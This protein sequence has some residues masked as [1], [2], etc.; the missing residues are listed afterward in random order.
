MRCAFSKRNAVAGMILAC[1]CYVL[2]VGHV[3]SALEAARPL[4]IKVDSIP[5]TELSDAAILFITISNGLQ[6][7]RALKVIVRIGGLGISDRAHPPFDL[8]VGQSR[9]EVFKIARPLRNYFVR[10]SYNVSG[11]NDEVVRTVEWPKTH[12]ESIL[13]LFAPVG[14]TLLGTMLGAWLLDHFS[15]RRERERA[16]VDWSRMLFEKYEKGYR[17]FLREWGGV[18]SSLIL[19]RQFEVLK[20]NCLVP[21][22]IAEAY[23]QTWAVVSSD[24]EVAA[25]KDEACAS[26]RSVIENFFREPW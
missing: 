24:K 7:H 14:G 18:S 25:R 23:N 21:A 11:K 5:P 19:S 13:P 9:L 3:A 17:D 2:F 8:E 12:R 10:V 4:D 15:S 6:E 26:L 1:A 20:E 22:F 16:K